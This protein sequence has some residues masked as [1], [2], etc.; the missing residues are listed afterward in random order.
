MTTIFKYGQYWDIAAT[1]FRTKTS[2]FKR[3]VEN[4]TKVTSDHPYEKC[5][6]RLK[7]KQTPS[8][9]RLDLKLFQSFNFARY[10]TCVTLHESDRTAKNVPNGKLHFFGNKNHAIARK[11]SLFSV[12][13]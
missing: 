6:Q 5:A 7:E 8:Q 3:V 1:A 4:Y 11:K 9:S 10:D 12:L 2:G 13:E